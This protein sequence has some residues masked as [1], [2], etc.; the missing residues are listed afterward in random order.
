[1]IRLARKAANQSDQRFKVGAA[2][3]KG[4]RTLAHACNTHKTC[5]EFG[6]KEYKYLHAEGAVIKKC[7]RQGID[8]KG[9]TIIVFRKGYRNS[10]PCPCCQV[11]I[12]AVGIT[13]VVYSDDGS[14]KEYTV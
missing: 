4:S 7:I 12:E 2:I 9:A 5:P 8:L 3:V 10:R 6:S 13:K 11:L 14:M 1:M